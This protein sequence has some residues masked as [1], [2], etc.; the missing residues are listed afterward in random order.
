MVT[1]YSRGL[2][3]VWGR[4]EDN[5]WPAMLA[6]ATRTVLRDDG[7]EGIRYVRTVM[8]HTRNGWTGF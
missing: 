8:G 2:L 7:L 1:P 4:L 3:A 6:A 5:P